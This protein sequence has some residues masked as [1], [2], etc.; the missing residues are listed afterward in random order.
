MREAA[1]VE[2]P[3]SFSGTGLDEVTGRQI[4]AGSS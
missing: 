1:L 2:V 3:T 4:K